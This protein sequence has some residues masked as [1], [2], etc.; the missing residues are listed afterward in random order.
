MFSA[1]KTK[2][3]KQSREAS[4]PTTSSI[5]QHLSPERYDEIRPYLRLHNHSLGVVFLLGALGNIVFFVT[6]WCSK[7]R[8]SPTTFF[9]LH[10]S[11]AD[12]LV[13]FVIPVGEMV[14][15]ATVAWRGGN[16]MCKLYHFLWQFG[17]YTTTYLLCCISIDRFLAFVFPLRF[18]TQSP[19]TRSLMAASAWVV[20]ALLSVPEVGQSTPI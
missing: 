7:N 8:K 17:H 10:L 16:F 12:L 1:K 19:H 4:D 9:L 18:V 6:L 14:N 13:M 3:G 11:S 5:R 20:S 15:N 2:V